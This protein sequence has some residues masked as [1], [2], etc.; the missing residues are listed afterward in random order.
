LDGAPAKITEM[1]ARK[2]DRRFAADAVAAAVAMYLGLAYVLAPFFWRHFERQ[3][4]LASFEATTRT[5]LGLPGDAINVGLEGPRMTCSAPC[6][7]LDGGPLTRS[8]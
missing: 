2:I 7:R 3:P 5:A 1:I 6:T 4:E 8:R